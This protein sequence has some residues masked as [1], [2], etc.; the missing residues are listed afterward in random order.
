MCSKQEIAAALRVVL[1][2]SLADSCVKACLRAAAMYA[3]SGDQLKQSKSSRAGLQLSVGRFHRW[4]ADVRLGRFIHEYAAIY[5]A[6]G[7]ENLLE[8]IVSQCMPHD[9][10]SMLTTAVLEAAIAANADFWGL[11]QPYAH[12]SSGRTAAG[13][14]ALPRWPSS[15]SDSWA[16]TLAS[17][18]DHHQAMNTGSSSGSSSS[19]I[20]SSVTSTGG[21]GTSHHRSVEQSL[22]TTCVGS[23]DE[24]KAVLCRVA[25]FHLAQ[26]KTGRGAAVIWSPSAV[27][28][29]FYFMRCSQVS[30][31]GQFPS[32]DNIQF[33]FINQLPLEHAK[34]AENRMVSHVAFCPPV[35]ELTWERPFAVLPPV[36]E[37]VRVAS[38]HAEY[39]SSQVVD[40]D[41]V[42]Q[43]ARLLL[44]GVDCP[45]RMPGFVRNS[46][47][48]SYPSR[49]EEKLETAE[50]LKIELAFRM[51]SS[52]R[53]DLLP[54]ALQL[55]PN[56]KV[57]TVNE[58]GFTPLMLA[59]LYDDESVVRYLIDAGA[60]V[61]AETPPNGTYADAQH[62]TALTYTA[63]VGDVTV[64]RV[65]LDHGAG[66]EGGARANEDRCT[67]TPLQVATA[68]GNTE[69][70][71][72][73]LSRGADPF[74]A[75]T[76][77]DSLAIAVAASH[78]QRMALHKLL[79]HPL[80]RSVKKE[81]LSLEEILAEGSSNQSTLERK[82]RLLHTIP[83]TKEE[84][85]SPMS[86]R[87]SVSDCAQVLKLTKAQVKILQE[88]MYHSAESQ[89][90]DITLDLR[91]LG[92]PWTLHC[93]MH[94]LAAAHEHR[95]ENIID[96]LL[97][98]FLQVWPDD[99]SPQF[100]DECLPLLFSIFRYSK[101][102]EGTTLL[103]AD[104]FSSCF[105]RETI[106]EV[107]DYTFENAIA[108]I[109]P[110][111]VNSPDLSDVRFRVEGRLFFAHKI[112]LVNASPRF[113]QMLGSR[114]SGDVEA[115]IVQIND[116]RYD[117]FEMVMQYLYQGGREEIHVGHNDVL[118]LM[119]AANFFQLDGLLRF[120]ESKCS[121]MVDLD[122]IV[123]MYIHAK[124]YSGVH[125]LE[126]C[127]GFLIQN[128]VAL[129]T[130]DD[131]VR[132]LI[133][134]KKLHNH[135]VLSGLLLTLQSRVR[136]KR[137]RAQSPEPGT[138]FF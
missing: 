54:H 122:N 11:L 4:M 23:L 76:M 123:S 111:F 13:A 17:M 61:N 99:Y 90:L 117:I 41:D 34:H 138:P 116:I 43:T 30:V 59:C 112:I 66:V 73:L 55:L 75:T 134:G 78:G 36:V 125:L 93:W 119:A 65:L 32:S 25:N 53:T 72:L 84:T 8:E 40:Q 133:F 2:S 50:K 6:A 83:P 35:Q 10:E 58:N 91:S 20:G 120:C 46:E 68:Y 28:A 69:V 129:L 67:E 31:S 56:T 52:G 51:L 26:A 82:T 77:K 101:Q 106:R 14:L 33:I 135:D 24:L 81:M 127:Q 100:V 107:K 114:F 16:R 37:W 105:G 71:A 22:L 102:N 126:Y 80:N 38:A 89:Y 110:K 49:R 60:D 128:M 108:R 109:D 42:M 63:L 57:N 21:H 97:Q 74:L 94:T 12:L 3:V 88:A 39:R 27:H 18:D 64:A 48:R 98:D 45:V 132:R 103:L 115:P 85:R 70:V 136:A 95:L 47:E 104:I 131:S 87:N 121:K 86:G 96:Q 5:L 92:I 29:L 44:P 15:S 113:R 124:V 118:E 130:Y 62:W 7:L 137:S 1:S 19:G 79:S 9:P